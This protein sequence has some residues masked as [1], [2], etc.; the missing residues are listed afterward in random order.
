MTHRTFTRRLALIASA[1]AVLVPAIGYETA[2]ASTGAIQ[3]APFC[4]EDNP[5][6][7]WAKMGNHKRG[8]V[9]VDGTP[10]IVGPCGFNRLWAH[11]AIRHFLVVDG[12]AYKSMS[13]LKGDTFA[14]TLTDCPWRIR[15]S[16]P[17]PWQQG[18]GA[19]AV[20]HGY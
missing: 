7:N 1:A 20:Q 12:H 13:K 18:P 8:V 15:E 17:F 5:C 10:K 6:W 11:G 19:W 2:N 9:L 16:R 14:R 3:P 4:A